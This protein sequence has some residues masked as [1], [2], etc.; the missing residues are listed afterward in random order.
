MPRNITITFAD[1][2][3]HVYQNAPDDVTPEAVQER[4]SKEFGKTVQSLGGGKKS[5]GY[6]ADRAGELRDMAAGAVRGAGNIAATGMR[7]L[8]NALGGDTAAESAERRTRLDENAR[9]LLGADTNSTSYKGGTLLGEVAGTAGVGNVIAAPFRAANVLPKVAEVLASGGFRTG[10]PAATSLAGKAGDLALRSGGGAVTGGVSAGMTDPGEAK[11]GAAIG[12]ALPGGI[13]IAGKAAQLV[14]AAFRSATTPQEV[15]LAN[16]LAQVLG[17]SADE[18]SAALTQQGP[19][20][21]PGYRATVPQILQRPE[22]SQMQRTVQAAG[23]QALGDANKVQ[24]GQFRDAIN[25]VAP[26]DLSV[27]D[28]AERAGGAIENFARPAERAAGQRV[29]ELF[30]AIPPDQATMQLPIAAMEAAQ[31]RFLGPGTFGKGGAPAA[32]AID[33][34]RQIGTDGATGAPLAVPFDQLQALRSSIGEAI[35]D[36][37]K[38]GRNQAAAALTQMKNAIDN[39]VAD[40]AAGNAVAGEVFTPQAI[41]TW[42]QALAAHGGKK[43]RFHT[44]PQAQMFRQGGDGQPALQGAEIPG[45]FFSGRRSQVE[46]VQSLKRLLGDRENLMAEMKR[47]ATT[48]GANTSNA[49]GDL[50]SKF[51]DWLQSRSGANRELFSE[52]ELATLKEVGK[53]VERSLKA[54]NLG[55]VSNSDTAQKTASMMDL[56]LLDNKLVNILANRIP[57]VGQFT[58]PMM[59]GLKATATKD[60]SNKLAQ[61]LA[62]PEFLNEALAAGVPKDSAMAAAMRRALPATYRVA[63]V[64]GA[65]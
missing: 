13:K 64:I 2:S 61:L 45:K 37:T 11:T 8:P 50:T 34:A 54:E 3:Q 24:Q 53:A 57:V 59:S 49:S 28:A 4:A 43:Q 38:N 55:R 21:I 27:Q 46:D 12:A 36:A 6:F 31:G 15:K 23:A 29:N 16:K 10:A 35:T 48:E 30:D 17:V 22:V 32:Q 14:G 9:N 25:R 63:P 56:G 33:T 51:T 40:V 7:I 47:Y 1:G 58:A 52:S 41:D 39:K 5:G 42:G 26:V 44:G 60:R 20:M 19:Q 62:D 18:L 65:Q